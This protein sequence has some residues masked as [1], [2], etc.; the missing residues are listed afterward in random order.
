MELDLKTREY[1]ML[2]EKLDELKQN[3]INENDEQLIKLKD[4]FQEN[5]EEI[6]NINKQIKELKELVNKEEQE[7]EENYNIDNVFKGRNANNIS[8]I[9]AIQDLKIVKKDNFFTK[10]INRLKGLFIKNN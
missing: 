6:A 2:C 5:Y 3:K 9:D 1:K 10:L 8:K 7:K 4:K